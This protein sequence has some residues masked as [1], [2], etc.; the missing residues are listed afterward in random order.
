MYDRATW[1]RI[2]PYIDTLK[3]GNTTESSKRFWTWAKMLSSIFKRA[4]SWKH[5]KQYYIII[6]IHTNSSF[7]GC[8]M[9][10]Q[11]GHTLYDKS[12]AEEHVR[13]NPEVRIQI[14]S[15]R[16]IVLHVPR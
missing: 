16:R 6:Y 1:R 3:S 5:G 12:T 4:K 10:S 2:S 9:G 7:I 13:K 11:D 14:R 8:I 15:V